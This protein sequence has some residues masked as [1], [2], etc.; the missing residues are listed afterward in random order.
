MEA[1]ALG[2]DL[3]HTPFGHAGESVL[4]VWCRENGLE[5][6]FQ[7]HIQS[8][9]VVE[10]LENEGKGLNL[11]REVVE[12]ILKHT[13]G[14]SDYHLTLDDDD[15]LHWEGRVVKIS[16]RIAYVNHDLQDAIEA[17]ILD[18]RDVP[19]LFTGLLGETNSERI[20]AMV[21][22]VI[23]S[24]MEKQSLSLTPKM[25]DAINGLK[26]FLFAQVYDHPKV[27]E[28]DDSIRRCLV[29]LLDALCNE[30]GVCEQYLK[31]WVTDETERKR[32]LVDYVAGMTDRYAIRIAGE[33]MLPAPWPVGGPI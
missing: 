29:G 10:V 23:K 13:K 31:G 21:K 32:R 17:G 8:V 11:S 6:G 1:I 28:H 9:R 18:L 12:G 14:R 24:T 25:Q 22:D 16:D 2:H 27:R 3:G 4:D 7:H 20:G 33:L 26:D 30:K 15:S 19:T 5:D